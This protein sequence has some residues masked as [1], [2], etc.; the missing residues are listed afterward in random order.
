MTIETS[1]LN[2]LLGVFLTAGIAFVAWIVHTLFDLK[3]KLLVLSTGCKFCNQHKPG[4]TE[5]LKRD[6]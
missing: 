3:F 1:T 4:G 5:F 6:I 2:V